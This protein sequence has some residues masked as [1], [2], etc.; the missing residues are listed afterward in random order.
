VT[1]TPTGYR[2]ALRSS[3]VRRLWL[4]SAASTV[5]DY[6]GLSALLFLA[7]DRTGRTV[8]GA[9][10]LAVAMAPSLIT[11][12]VAGSWLDRL[13]RARTLAILQVAGALIIC[14]PLVSD[15][16]PVIYLTAAL[17]AVV[18]TATIAVRSG[19]MAEGVRDDHRGPLI[20]L[21]ASTDQASQV[22][23]FLTGGAVYVLLGVE[24]ALLLD[25]VS[26]LVGA[27]I[28]FGLRLPEPERRARRAPITAGLRDLASDPV[29]RLLAT[30]V[31][32]TGTVASL[33]ETLAP[34]V[35][36]RGDPMRPLVL[37][38]APAGQALAMTLLGRLPHLRRPTFQL[39]HFASLGLALA[40]AAMVR[41]PVAVAAANLFVGA[42]VAWIVG[43]QLTFLRLA[44]KARMA[45]ISGSMVAM[46]AVADGLGSLG[47]AAVADLAGVQVAYRS[48]AMLLLAAA[49]VGWLVKERTPRALALDRDDLPIPPT[50]T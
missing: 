42:G 38:A 8:G 26:F 46:L 27:A 48:A 1:T 12:L 39:V 15:E 24:T 7:A 32:I 3:L 43:P 17:L 49:A 13:P 21:M 37:A 36:A 5:G 47:F 50:S 11:G 23:G 28:L 16:V 18:R 35:A 45:Q 2:A 9:V 33:P 34:A 14:L 40:V 20:A 19:A 10:V 30:L 25:A 41:T 44:P 4:A 31:V 29:L 22:L 6:I